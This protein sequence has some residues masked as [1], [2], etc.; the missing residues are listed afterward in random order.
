R[1]TVNH[2]TGEDTVL[3]HLVVSVRGDLDFPA[4]HEVRNPTKV[5]AHVVAP[6]I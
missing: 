2:F 6:F 4:L 1:G 3:S 5:I